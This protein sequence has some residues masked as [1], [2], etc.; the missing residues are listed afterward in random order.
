VDGV[1]T[2]KVEGTIDSGELREALG[3]A[4]E[5]HTVKAEAW[6]GAED[7]LPRRIRLTGRLV[8]TENEDVQRQIDLSRFGEPVEINPP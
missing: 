7:S 6:I 2:L 4:R 5:G 1:A 3:F 8:S